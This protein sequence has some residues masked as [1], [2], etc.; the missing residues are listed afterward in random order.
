MKKRLII[1]LSA[2]FCMGM[3]AVP[4]TAAEVQDGQDEDILRKLG[5]V[6]SA[7]NLIEN[8]G[9]FSIEDITYGEE[10]EEK[11]FIYVDEDRLAREWPAG[12]LDIMDYGQ[13]KNIYSYD[14]ET[15]TLYE[16]LYGDDTLFEQMVSDNRPEGTFVF[17]EGENVVA[18]ENTDE[19]RKIVTETSWEDS[20]ENQKEL[21]LK[22]EETA[23]F[24]YLVD[25]DTF[26]LKGLTL[27]FVSPD[28]AERMAVKETFTAGAKRYELPEKYQE[29]LQ[30]KDTR[31]MTLV[32]DAGTE[33]E[34]T[35]SKDIPKGVAAA[36]LIPAEYV[37]YD[38]EACTQLH[39]K[40][41]NFDEDQTL[42]AAKQDEEPLNRIYEANATEELLKKHKNIQIN[43]TE[44]YGDEVR[45]YFCYYDADMSVI[46]D[47]DSNVQIC[48]NGDVYGFLADQAAPFR[49]LCMDGTYEKYFEEPLRNLICLKL[50]GERVIFSGEE[51]GM[52][53]VETVM[54]REDSVREYP[55]DNNITEMEET[56]LYVQKYVADTETYEIQEYFEYIEKADGTRKLIRESKLSYDGEKYEVSEELEAQLDSGDT[57]TVTLIADPGTDNEKEY[58]VSVCKGGIVQ[59]ILGE[60][61]ST[62]YSD[63]ACT[64]VYEGIADRE[65]DKTLYTKKS[66]D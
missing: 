9:S 60:G 48:E 66:Q 41:D 8:Y 19:G 34:E 23:K 43:G 38:D 25:P 46:E 28:G 29:M 4:A 26:V 64:Q 62:F 37:L 59:I 56:D 17:L 61:Y 16:L 27:S 11:L 42:Y 1:L 6:N 45:I 50:E 31:K 39:E 33:Q 21:G 2:V 35:F 63:E 57:R 13:E 65:N 30:S 51:N 12:E 18:D 44:Y 22:E 14:P 49:G 32:M 36:V 47:G 55:D 54:N 15:D 5:E 53:T 58:S 10:G 40:N 3:T 20:P 52:L 24:E 7:E